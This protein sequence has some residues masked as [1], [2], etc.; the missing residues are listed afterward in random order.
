MLRRG[1]VAAAV[2]CL[3]LASAGAAAQSFEPHRIAFYLHDVDG[4]SRY[5]APIRFELDR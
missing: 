3:A 5:T 1:R 2:L 4:E